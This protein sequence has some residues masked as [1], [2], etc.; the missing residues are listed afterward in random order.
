MG[1]FDDVG[2]FGLDG[3]L[4]Y[5]DKK[6]IVLGKQIVGLSANLPLQ[7]KVTHTS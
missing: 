2:T 7:V 3:A 1:F 4:F 6:K 5:S